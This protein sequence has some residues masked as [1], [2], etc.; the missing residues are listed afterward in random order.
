MEIIWRMKKNDLKI[1][2]VERFENEELI[3]KNFGK[4]SS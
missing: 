4:S 1:K 3:W 2:N